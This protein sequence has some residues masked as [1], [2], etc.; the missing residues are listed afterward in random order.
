MLSACMNKDLLIKKVM[1]SN[2]AELLPEKIALLSG[3]DQERGLPMV[4]QYGQER[5]EL[6]RREKTLKLGLD[7]H[8]RQ[9]TVAMQEEGG[10]VRPVG[11]M[12]Y[13]SFLPWIEKKLGQGWRIY[14]CYEAGAS[15]YWLDRQLRKLGVANLV[16]VPKAM[17][18]GGKK[19]KTDRRDSCQLLDDLDRYMRGNP[20]AFSV[21]G[22]PSEEQEEKRALIRYQVQIM[23]DRKRCEARGKGLLCSQGI[24]VQGVWWSEAS[25]QALRQNPALK[26]WM[27]EQLEGWRSKALRYEEEQNQLRLRLEALAPDSLPKG[28]GRYSWAV[29]EYEMKGWGRFKNRRQVGS[30]TG[31]CPGVHRSDQSGREGSINRCGNPIVRWI[32]I[33]MVWRLLRWQP[34]YPPIR[35]LVKGL[36]RSKRARKRLAVMAARHLAIDLWRLATG[37]TTAEKLGLVF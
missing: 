1:E 23:G 36:V 15:G 4:I 24:E 7:L 11:K 19:Q 10:L 14:S 26:D 9:V 12:D 20:K 37:Q 5:L 30:Y 34:A 13:R 25:W 28:L 6:N 35:Q 3:L 2:I 22:V 27:K 8:Y 31:L 33:E 29:L 16:V 17:G 18:Q 32:L 21:V